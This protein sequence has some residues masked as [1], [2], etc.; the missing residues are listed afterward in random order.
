MR[1]R[2][3]GKLWGHLLTEFGVGYFS[4]CAWSSPGLA[5][6]QVPGSICLCAWF[7]YMGTDRLNSGSHAPCST[8]PVKPFPT[9][10]SD[11]K[12]LLSVYHFQ[13]WFILV[14]PRPIQCALFISVLSDFF[15]LY[16]QNTLCSQ[17]L[18]SPQEFL[19]EIDSSVFRVPIGNVYPMLFNPL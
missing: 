15:F 7:V 6:H 2:G 5:G 16:K 9:P 18:V 1:E 17:K 19:C 10:I 4:N 13:V 12:L 11:L 14:F 3:W 8:L